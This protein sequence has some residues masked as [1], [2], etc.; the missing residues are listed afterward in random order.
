MTA[1]AQEPHLHCRPHPVHFSQFQP[2]PDLSKRDIV[3][4]TAMTWSLSGVVRIDE[5]GRADSGED[6]RVER[7]RH[8]ESGTR[9]RTNSGRSGAH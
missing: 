8:G 1:P 5:L 3:E 9:I 2:H 4:R 6:D 7:A